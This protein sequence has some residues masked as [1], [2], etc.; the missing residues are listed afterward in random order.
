[1]HLIKSA[2]WNFLLKRLQILPCQP[3]KAWIKV[4]RKDV[5]G[6]W[7][8]KRAD[9]TQSASQT[10]QTKL[11]ELPKEQHSG[12]NSLKLPIEPPLALTQQTILDRYMGKDWF[13]HLTFL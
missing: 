3:D 10:T 7:H 8:I 2:I 5:P 1:M 6:F 4:Y 11:S 9:I 13:L 12:L